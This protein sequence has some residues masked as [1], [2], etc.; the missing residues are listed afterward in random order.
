MNLSHC[1]ISRWR[2]DVMGH[3]RPKCDG[4]G[5]SALPPVS[6]QI[7]APRNTIGQ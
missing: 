2:S 1:V 4:R 5:M 7:A 3:K 6:D